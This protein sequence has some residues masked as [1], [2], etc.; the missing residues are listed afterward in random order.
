MYDWVAY[1]GV[2]MHRIARGTSL[3]Q[4]VLLRKRHLAGVK[5]IIPT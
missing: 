2:T 1:P 5:V 4:R 3:G